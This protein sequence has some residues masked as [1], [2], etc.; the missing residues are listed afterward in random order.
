MDRVAAGVAGLLERGF[1]IVEESLD[2]EARRVAAE[3][4]DGL[5]TDGQARDVGN[6]YVIHP[7]VTRDARI[8]DLFL[9]PTVLGIMAALFQDEPLLKHSGSRV[10]DRYHTARLGWHI[11]PAAREE[12][13]IQPGD[14][15]RGVRPRR[16]LCN[17]YV[18]G[19][20]PESGPLLVL[21]RQYD[22]LLAPPLED[23]G[24]AWPSEVAVSCPPGSAVIF[25]I[26]VW[27]AALPGTGGGRRR[28]FGGHF[29]GRN[30]NLPHGED[31]VQEGPIVEEG[32]ARNSSF[33]RLMGRG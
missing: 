17:W 21:P 23:R 19:L 22:D 2:A 7:L 16:V 15:R 6:G 12:Q 8:H 26:D 27:H 25:S 14:P 20:S 4:L 29:Q 28:L 24:V 18:E 11:H 32:I 3:V 13:Q 5:I 31:Q 9:D 30:D 1:C 33:A 10:T